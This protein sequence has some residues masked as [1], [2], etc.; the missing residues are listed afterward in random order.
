[1]GPSFWAPKQTSRRIPITP[2]LLSHV[3]HRW[4]E[5]SLN[6]PCLWSHINL[7]E[8]TPAGVAGVLTLAKMVP[9]HLEAAGVKTWDIKN[10]TGQIEAHIHHTRRLSLSARSEDLER[11]LGRLISSAPSLEQLS[12]NSSN[13]TNGAM[14]VPDI[15]FNGIAPK[16]SYLRLN[17]C[18]ISWVSP[19]L[20]G[21]RVLELFT[22]PKGGR[23]PLNEWFDAL[24][25]MHHLERLSLHNNIPS[26]NPV[27]ER[28]P[29]EPG[30]A[31]FIPSLKELDI[32]ASEAD[33]FVVLAHLILPALTRLCVVT[34]TECSS[35]T[36]PQLISCVARNAYGPQDTEALQSLFIGG[37]EDKEVT[38]VAWTVPRQ[39]DTYDGSRFSVDLPDGIRLARV[40]FCMRS[41]FR[42]SR[43][44]GTH[45]ELLAALPLNHIVS[46]TIK[47]RALHRMPVWR[48][49][50][51]R[52]NKLQRVRLFSSAV[53]SFQNMLEDAPRGNPLLP[54]LEELVLIDVPLTAQM[55]YYLYNILS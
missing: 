21:L 23:T 22:F 15:L 54:S 27:T 50:A 35:V 6:L 53:P 32:L 16:L 33:C 49:N 34:E 12:I 45:H 48:D 40:A 30:L 25:Q 9:L 17:L 18:S 44:A 3:C 36:T 52:W 46:L 10:V 38:A 51:S 43:T 14:L 41:P 11:M 1:M 29:M 55:V 7:T 26:H 28:T 8:L 2:F 42:L 20:K 39:D 31:I 24:S 4:R 47:D 37:L 5:I 13:L 19:L